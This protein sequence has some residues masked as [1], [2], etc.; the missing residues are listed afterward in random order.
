MLSVRRRC[1]LLMVSQYHFGPNMKIS[2]MKTTRPVKV[3]VTGKVSIRIL[4]YRNIN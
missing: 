4:G 2:V 3:T 1:L